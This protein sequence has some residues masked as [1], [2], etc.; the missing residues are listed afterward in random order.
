LINLS[1]PQFITAQQSRKSSKEIVIKR[2][3]CEKELGPG[4]TGNLPENLFRMNI[5]LLLG[6][7]WLDYNPKPHWLLFTHISPLG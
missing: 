3:F 1:L 2:Q 7:V 5:L 6:L 4:M